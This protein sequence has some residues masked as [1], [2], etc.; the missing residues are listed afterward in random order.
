MTSEILKLNLEGEICPY[1]LIRTIKKVEEIKKDLE[2][3]RKILEVFY[4]HPPVVD[5]IPTELKKRGFQASV[6]KIK[7]AQWRAVISSAQEQ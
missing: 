6:E 2:S 4:D 5:N 7:V 1:T 3:G